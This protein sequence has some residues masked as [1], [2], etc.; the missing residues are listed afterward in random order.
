MT[1]DAEKCGGI[2][3]VD[4]PSVSLECLGGSPLAPPNLIAVLAIP[5][6]DCVFV[7]TFIEADC[8]PKFTSRWSYEI[9]EGFLC[10]CIGETGQMTI[11]EV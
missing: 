4:A 9:F 1:L 6:P 3:P 7:V 10:P 5:L 8:G 11:N 2:I